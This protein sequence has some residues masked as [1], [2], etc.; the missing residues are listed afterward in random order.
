M[1]EARAPS[2]TP[3]LEGEIPNGRRVA[4]PGS[5]ARASPRPPPPRRRPR[6]P[7]RLQRLGGGA[8]RPRQGEGERAEG[9]QGVHNAH[10]MPYPRT[11]R[12]SPLPWNA[13]CG[14]L[15]RWEHRMWV[16]GTA[17]SSPRCADECVPEGGTYR[18]TKVHI[19]LS[20]SSPQVQP[21]RLVLRTQNA[22][23]TH[24]HLRE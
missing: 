17:Y 8:G 14:F 4:A 1:C 22:S 10:P 23:R 5:G 11:W 19:T 13:R 18:A 15:I 6:R 20:A 3:R 9:P 7:R 21:L 24:T 16:A 12:P 2:R